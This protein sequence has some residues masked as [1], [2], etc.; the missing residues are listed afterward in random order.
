MKEPQGLTV[1]EGIWCHGEWMGD[2]EGNIQG[3]CIPFT[4][5]R[6]G[7]FY[8]KQGVYEKMGLPVDPSTLTV[9]DALHQLIPLLKRKEELR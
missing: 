4:Q 7:E 3:A 6:D 2:E 8:R 1:L 9:D 5:M